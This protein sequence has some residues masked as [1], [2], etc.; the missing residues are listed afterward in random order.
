MLLVSNNL[1]TI[2]TRGANEEAKMLYLTFC[3]GAGQIYSEAVAAVCSE[4]P[5]GDP[6]PNYGVS[7]YV[8]A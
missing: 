1:M 2:L 4:S 6:E 3:E 7:R 5:H 8:L